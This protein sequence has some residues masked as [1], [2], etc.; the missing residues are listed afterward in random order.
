MM[1]FGEALKVVER[2]SIDEKKE[3]K[4]KYTIKPFKERKKQPS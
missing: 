2:E 4:S 1:L 3:K